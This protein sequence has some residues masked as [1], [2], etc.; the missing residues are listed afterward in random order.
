M[1]NFKTITR[2]R[3][4][5]KG[6]NGQNRRIFEGVNKCTPYVLTRHQVSPVLHEITARNQP[7]T[8]DIGTFIR[9]RTYH[10]VKREHRD[11]GNDTQKQIHQKSFRLNHAYHLLSSAGMPERQPES[12]LRRTSPPHSRSSA[13]I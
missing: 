1:V 6:Y 12:K 5:H 4:Y 2:Q 7:S 13:H 8:H 9:R 11:K 10:P 3:A